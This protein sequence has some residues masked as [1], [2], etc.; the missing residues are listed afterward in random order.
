M[1]LHHTILLQLS[2]MIF[3]NLLDYFS[4][5]NA[6]SFQYSEKYLVFNVDFYFASYSSRKNGSQTKALT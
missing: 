5:T 3:G 4:L 1:K 6:I 2:A